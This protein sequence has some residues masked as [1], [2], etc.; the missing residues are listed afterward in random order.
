[1]QQLFCH[2]ST[3]TSRNNK[4]R[5]K[6]SCVTIEFIYESKQKIGLGSCAICNFAAQPMVRSKLLKV[7]EK[8][9]TK[10]DFET[11]LIDDL[12]IKFVLSVSD[13][14]FH[15]GKVDSNFTCR[16]VILLH[17][18]FMV[19]SHVN[20]FSFCSSLLSTKLLFSYF[21]LFSPK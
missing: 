5:N 6:S 17:H 13:Q 8:V 11:V 21:Y 14:Y 12:N 3:D 10:A 9:L 16:K 7:L 1:L 15:Q 2:G 4:C 19:L 18:M 20:S